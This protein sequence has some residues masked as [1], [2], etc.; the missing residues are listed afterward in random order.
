VRDLVARLA[1]RGRSGGPRPDRRGPLAVAVASALFGTITVGGRYFAMQGLSLLEISLTQVL[2]AAIVLGAV[3]IWQPRHRP[4]H[5]EIR[6]F[7]LFGMMGAGLQLTQFAGIILGVPVALVAL[8]LYSQPIWTALLGRVWLQEPL[9]PR[10]LVAVAVAVAGAGVLVDPWSARTSSYS[11]AGLAAAAAGGLL[12]S[13]WVLMSR[14]SGLRGNHPL[15]TSFAYSASTS[16]WLLAITPL[17]RLFW[18]EPAFVRLHPGVWLGNWRAVAVYTLVASL[19]PALLANWGLRRVEASKGGVLLLF[20]PV[21]A[22][23]L[24]YALFGEPLGVRIGLGGLL[25][26]A[27]NVVVL[28][29]RAG[30]EQA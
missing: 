23:L 18:S 11:T 2:F 30:S 24:A 8:L 13:L 6:F 12:L 17:L 5:S 9:T 16:L 4:A 19:L 10:K 14:S 7:L 20:E 27:S 29:E 21:S 3:L 28:S 26:L 25:V 15:T 22:A 1:V